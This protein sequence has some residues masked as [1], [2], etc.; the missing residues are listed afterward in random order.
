MARSKRTH[1]GGQRPV[2]P[3]IIA[4]EDWDPSGQVV[5]S[6]EQTQAVMDTMREHGLV[7]VHLAAVTLLLMAAVGGEEAAREQLRK[8][9]DAIQLPEHLKDGIVT[10]VYGAHGPVPR[11]KR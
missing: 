10:T 6:Q 4:I 5:L 7:P 2:M 9:A 11:L 3:D 8:L 1:H